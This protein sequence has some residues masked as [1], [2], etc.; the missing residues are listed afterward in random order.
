MSNQKCREGFFFQNSFRSMQAKLFEDHC[1]MTFSSPA[2]NK[3]Q[4][5]LKFSSICLIARPLENLDQHISCCQLSAFCALFISPLQCLI[6]ISNSLTP[7]YPL[8]PH[9]LLFMV[10]KVQKGKSKT[11]L[12]SSLSL[13]N[14]HLE[15]FQNVTF[16]QNYHQHLY[17]TFQ[18][19]L[20][21]MVGIFIPFSSTPQNNDV[22][23]QLA[24]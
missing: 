15:T 12:V 20:L 6:S 14:K 3:N 2:P 18:R 9:G 19:L 5:K 21:Y 13:R 23:Q 8:Q 24:G 22:E 1:Y 10:D 7:V 4:A 16:H 17:E 11:C